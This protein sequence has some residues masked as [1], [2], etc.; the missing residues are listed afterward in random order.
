MTTEQIPFDETD[1]KWKRSVQFISVLFFFHVNVQRA[2]AECCVLLNLL[3]PQ[4][5][6][7]PVLYVLTSLIAAQNLLCR[8]LCRAC[9]LGGGSSPLRCS[10]SSNSITRHTSNRHKTQKP[11]DYP[12]GKADSSPRGSNC[13][14]GGTPQAP[15]SSWGTHPMWSCHTVTGIKYITNI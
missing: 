2:D 13:N 7:N 8:T 15:D 1:R 5:S 10:R 4:T 12:Q 6:P 11:P 9:S 14:G 3:W